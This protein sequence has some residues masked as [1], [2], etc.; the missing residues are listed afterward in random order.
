MTLT[1]LLV[2]AI[3]LAAGLAIALGLRALPTLWQRL[4]GLAVLAVCLPLAAVLLSGWAMAQWPYLVYPDL[5]VADAAAPPATL[6]ATLWVVAIGMVPL[7]PS[8]WYLFAVFK[9]ENP[10]AQG[11]APPDRHRR[12]RP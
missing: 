12:D 6:R 7:I 10:A 2:A 9:A 1:A 3:T 4:A 11:A 5:T 8:L